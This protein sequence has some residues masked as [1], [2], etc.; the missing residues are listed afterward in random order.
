LRADFIPKQSGFA[1]RI[2]LGALFLKIIVPRQ[3]ATQAA[4]FRIAEEWGFLLSQKNISLAGGRSNFSS[5][6]FFFV[7]K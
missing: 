2:T 6:F 7:D 3:A 1:R 5:Y 4:H